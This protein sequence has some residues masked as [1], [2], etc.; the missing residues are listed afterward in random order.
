MHLHA[1]TVTVGPNSLGIPL[2]FLVSSMTALEMVHI[3][4]MSKWESTAPAPGAI[5]VLGGVVLKNSQQAR[6]QFLLENVGASKPDQA[7]ST[8]ASKTRDQKGTGDSKVTTKKPAQYLPLLGSWYLN[9]CLNLRQK[10]EIVDA[11]WHLGFS[12]RFIAIAKTFVAGKPISE[13]A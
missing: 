3:H 1:V 7:Y 12:P 13:V 5:G 10:M 4:G 9:S 2:P 11:L 6:L 8:L